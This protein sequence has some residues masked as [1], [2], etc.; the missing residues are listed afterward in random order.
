MLPTLPWSHLYLSFNE[1]QVDTAAR[2]GPISSLSALSYDPPL[3][4][5]FQSVSLSVRLMTHDCW[6]MAA[7][8]SFL[9]TVNL[10]LFGWHLTGG[11]PPGDEGFG[12]E[13]QER[14][15]LPPTWK[16]K[17][18]AG[19]VPPTKSN[20]WPQTSIEY[21]AIGCVLIIVAQVNVIEEL[22]APAGGRW[23]EKYNNV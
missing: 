6:S 9:T 19:S 1:N 21:R 13:E 2:S 23:G 10:W 3:F 8:V 7:P 22:A 11:G 12:H 20:V 5:F 15:W 17:N 18:K 16:A 4:S 14:C